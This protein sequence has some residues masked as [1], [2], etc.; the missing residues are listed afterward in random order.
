MREGNARKFYRKW[1]NVKF[2]RDPYTLR[3]QAKKSYE[4]KNWGISIKTKE[5]LEEKYGEDI[6]FGI[7]ITLKEINGVNRIDEF[8]SQCAL[9]GWLVNR[10]NVENRLDVYNIAEEEIEFE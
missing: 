6:K 8:I 3:P 10:I 9:K 1:D 2:I 4:N 5:R 7:V